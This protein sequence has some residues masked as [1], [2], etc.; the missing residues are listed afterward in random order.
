MPVVPR[1]GQREVPARD[2]AAVVGYQAVIDD[3]ADEAPRDDAERAQD[4]DGHEQQHGDGE[5][6]LE[7]VA[8]LERRADDVVGGPAEHPGVGDRGGAEHD[9]ADH[10]DR[11]QPALL[12]DAPA[13]QPE[14]PPHHAVGVGAQEVLLRWA[15]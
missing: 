12:G 14:T 11:E 13:E 8:P 2:P 15:I 10:G 1:H 7:D 9:A 4:R 3:A 6:T 5:G